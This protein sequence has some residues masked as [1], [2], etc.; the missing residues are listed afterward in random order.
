MRYADS[1]NG[2]VVLYQRLLVAMVSPFPLF[3]LIVSRF[4]LA[5]AALLEACPEARRAPLR[6][7]VLNTPDRVRGGR[8]GTLAAGPPGGRRRE[9]LQEHVRDRIPSEKPEQAQPHRISQTYN[10]RERGKLD[11]T[12][13]K[14]ARV[15]RMLC[16][17]RCTRKRRNVVARERRRD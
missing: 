12:C 14:E 2:I 11:H 17:K 9:G 8:G 5:A 10:K 15:R 4:V 16:Q 6:R 3:F 7:G 13:L 1:R